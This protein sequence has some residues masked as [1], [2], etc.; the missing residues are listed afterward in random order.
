MADRPLTETEWAVRHAAADMAKRRMMP[1]FD[2]LCES[3]PGTEEPAIRAAIH[4]LVKLGKFPAPPEPKAESRTKKVKGRPV[5]NKVFNVALWRIVH[6]KG[7]IYEALATVTGMTVDALKCRVERAREV[8]PADELDPDV[9]RFTLAESSQL[10][11]AMESYLRRA[12]DPAVREFADKTFTAK[13][14]RP[15]ARSQVRD[16]RRK[17]MA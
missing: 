3:L 13:R 2:R 11:R 15:D 9:N 17:A 16:D 5:K 12:H 7:A 8:Y 1:T 14:A 10:S 6:G 4:E